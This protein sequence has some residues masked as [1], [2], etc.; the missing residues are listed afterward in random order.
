MEGGQGRR[1]V[2]LHLHHAARPFK[3]V[4]KLKRSQ[5]ASRQHDHKCR[6]FR[7]ARTSNSFKRMPHS[8]PHSGVMRDAS[9]LG[10]ARMAACLM[11]WLIFR[12][13]GPPPP[14]SGMA[15]CIQRACNPSTQSCHAPKA[16]NTYHCLW[17]R[18][19]VVTSLLMINLT[20][21]NVQTQVC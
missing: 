2:R 18:L 3:H 1:K 14:F 20:A 7:P 12:L 19:T 17:R 4:C 9:R 21:A 8:T 10:P 16:R 11:L 5:S 13:G 15:T 6:I